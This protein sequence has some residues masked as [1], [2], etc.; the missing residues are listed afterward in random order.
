MP[1]RGSLLGIRNVADRCTI[2]FPGWDVP[3]AN[4]ER[5]VDG[6]LNTYAGTARSTLG[7]AGVAGHVQI[8]FPSPGVYLVGG[9]YGVWSSDGSTRIS[10]EVYD[11]GVWRWI[12][13][14]MGSTAASSERVVSVLPILVGGEGARH[15]V[16]V[17]TAATVYLNIYELFVY[18]LRP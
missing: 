14:V 6:D 11:D 9:K 2:Q 17:N 1:H 7:S 10:V 5:A 16:Y 18:K 4:P 15:S 13:T 12:E 8:M 3:P